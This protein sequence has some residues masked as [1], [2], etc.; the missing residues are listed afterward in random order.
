MQAGTKQAG[1]LAYYATELVG[2]V[3][4]RGWDCFGIFGSSG[5]TIVVSPKSQVSPAEFG[6]RRELTGPAVQVS[7]TS[8]NN[9]S[10]VEVAQ[11]VARVFPAHK[12][13]VGALASADS[14][15]RFPSGPYPFDILK[16]KG[17]SLVEFTTPP[18]QKGLGTHLDLR[19]ND[20]PIH[21][22]AML[23]GETPSLLMLAVRL[24]KDLSH[25]TPVIIAEF[26][27]EAARLLHSQSKA[28]P[29][30]P[31][32]LN[33]VPF[34]GCPSDG[35]LGP[36]AAPKGISRLANA[37]KAE[38]KQL[39]YYSLQDAGLVAPRGWHCFGFYGS[40]GHTLIVS[41]NPIARGQVFLTDKLAGPAVQITFK[42][43][44]SSGRLEVAEVIARVFPQYR[45]FVEGVIGLFPNFARSIPSGPYPLDILN[46]QSPAVVEFTTPA[47]ETGLG[48]QSV[49]LPNSSPIRGVAMLVG[50]TP[51]LLMLTVRLPE[52]LAHL[53]PVITA[54]FLG[55]ELGRKR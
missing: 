50:D 52:D 35:Q 16:Y 47:H 30:T 26:E 45:S 33:R 38:A 29:Q 51:D 5:F 20:S 3:A 10:A 21:G 18:N 14:S 4:P 55:V 11:V 36:L 34:V 48:T 25:L 28:G 8:G 49:F 7:Y 43:G 9:F 39:A 42:Y 6:P 22:A 24:P 15:E 2:T 23:V 32:I 41:P 46:Y 31:L 54:Q 17:S 40:S 53:T 19:P 1:E 12:A 13:I 37:S 27:R 44:D